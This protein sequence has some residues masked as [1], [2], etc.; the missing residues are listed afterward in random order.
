MRARPQTSGGVG[1]L[2]GR[3]GGGQQVGEGGRQALRERQDN[4]EAA[5]AMRYRNLG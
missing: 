4:L 1:D 3:G 5:R 2:V